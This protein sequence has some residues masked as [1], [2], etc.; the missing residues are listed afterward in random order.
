MGRRAQQWARVSVVVVVELHQSWLRE[1]SQ[2]SSLV[3]VQGR[4][5]HVRPITTHPY[6][7]LSAHLWGLAERA[8]PVP[9]RQ[10]Q[11]VVARADFTWQSKDRPGACATVE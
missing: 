10:M 2:D 3:L 11:P 8:E 7:S 9:S 5:L 4:S 6:L 1:R